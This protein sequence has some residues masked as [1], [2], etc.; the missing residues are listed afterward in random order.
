MNI[1]EYQAKQI[2]SAYHIPC[3]GFRIIERQEDIDQAIDSLG[4]TEAVIK[5]QV[6]AGGRGKAG[7][8]KIAK[9]LA[10]IKQ[11][12]G[13]LLGMKI[14]TKQTGPEG[15]ICHRVMISE[16]AEIAKEYYV[17]LLIDRAHAK[18]LLMVSPEGG[19]EIEELAENSPHKI[20]KTHFQIDGTIDEMS[21]ESV[22]RFMDWTG[23]TKEEGKA[24]IKNLCRAFVD[25]DGEM[26]EINPLIEDKSGS[27]WA[28]DAKFIVDDNAL[29]RRPE[30]KAMYDP[31][32]SS[33]QEVIAHAMDLAYIA[34]DGNIGCMVNGAG[35]AMATMDLIKVHGGQPANFLDVGGGANKEK[36]SKSFA[37]IL[38][39]PNVK[40][41]LV[42]IFGGIMRCDVIAEGII[43]AA[44]E[45]HIKVPLVVR[46]EGTNV[47]KG[48]ELLKNSGLKIIAADDLTD[49]AKK[50]VQSANSSK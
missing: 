3:Q 31:T 12:A 24:L 4:V 43:E 17:G 18:P 13:E 26:L 22:C 28:L 45:L 10:E 6:H 34:L 47:V 33:P 35:L 39:D 1:H 36:V 29:F 7:G 30:I 5:V 19:T 16:L 44:R 21:L 41:I 11:K 20:L 38:S 37:L 14:V 23:K 32:Q 2:L 8:V 40:A 48:K 9:N 42:N 50:V 25:N 27:L 15:I 46:L 49:A